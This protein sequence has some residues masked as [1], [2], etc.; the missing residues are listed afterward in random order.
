MPAQEPRCHSSSS[1][2]GEWRALTSRHLGL[3]TL[4]QRDKGS[5]GYCSALLR[6][7]M[8]CV[9]W[10]R[11][12]GY[13]DSWCSLAALLLRER[14]RACHPPVTLGDGLCVSH[15]VTQ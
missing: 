1:L 7:R 8:R 9:N 15:S 12:A 4:T 13:G 11:S 2:G 14:F 3:V 6:T 10:K 5:A